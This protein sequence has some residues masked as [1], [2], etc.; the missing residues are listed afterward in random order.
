MSDL[1]SASA[2]FTLR[3]LETEGELV[4]KPEFVGFFSETES[5][6]EPVS[7]TAEETAEAVEAEEE[8]PRDETPSIEDQTRKAFEDAYAEGEKAGYEMGMRRAESVAKRLEKQIGE[9][10]LFKQELARRCEKLSTELALVFAEALVLRECSVGKDVLTD[11]VRKALAAREEKNE[12]VVRIRSE[13]L[14][15]VEALA[16]DQ[17]K[18]VADD[19]LGEPGFVI[20]TN[21]GD[22]DGKISTQIEELKNALT[23]YHAS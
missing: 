18:V 5:E 6:T 3:D 19:T 21:V 15:H 17:I 20:E 7:E 23:G 9:V 4:A 11:M 12:L 10:V 1:S 2:P 14:R 13:D 22:I 16:S 8:T